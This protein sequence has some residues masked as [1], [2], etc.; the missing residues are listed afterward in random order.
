MTK[1]LYVGNLAPETTEAKLQE[2]FTT[3]GRD[4]QK[5]ELA[6]YKKNGKSRGFGF[7]ELASEE[8][9]QAALESL[10][11]TSLDGRELK[12]GEA[13]NV[14][15][16]ERTPKRES[17]YGGGGGRFGGGGKRGRR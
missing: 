16:S 12:L 8:E 3:G 11:G 2:L 10:Q 14:K 15:K 17:D 5:V 6:T 1:T 13:T 4:V 9:A 7:V